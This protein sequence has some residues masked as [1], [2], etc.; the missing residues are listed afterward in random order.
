MAQELDRSAR[1]SKRPCCP[2][3]KTLRGPVSPRSNGANGGRQAV[4]VEVDLELGHGTRIP[5]LIYQSDLRKIQD[6][7]QQPFTVW[8]VLGSWLI[9]L[10]SVD[11]PTWWTKAPG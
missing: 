4:F 10:M 11:L 2:T 5:W 1:W 9:Y 3:A 8:W 7:S 6:A